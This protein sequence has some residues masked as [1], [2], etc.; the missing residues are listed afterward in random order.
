MEEMEDSSVMLDV[1]LR[2]MER[3]STNHVNRENL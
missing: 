3:R 2:C 1:Q